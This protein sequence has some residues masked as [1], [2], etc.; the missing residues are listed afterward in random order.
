[1]NGI[2]TNIYIL[3]T[4]NTWCSVRIWTVN[5][6]AHEPLYCTDRMNVAQREPSCYE[7]TAPPCLLVYNIYDSSFRFGCIRGLKTEGNNC[8]QNLTFYTNIYLIQL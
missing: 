7:V 8:F 4:T 1:M 2:K 5:G 3:K 6:G